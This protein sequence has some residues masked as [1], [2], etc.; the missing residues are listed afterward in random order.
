MTREEYITYRTNGNPDP[1][2]EVY[3]E[4]FNEKKHKPFLNKGDFFQA[5]QMW[6]P[7]M[8]ALQDTYA[9]FDSKFEVLIIKNKEGNVLKFV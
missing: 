1:V 3:K 5:I 4:G 9:Y 6:P 2:Y 8:K 7:A